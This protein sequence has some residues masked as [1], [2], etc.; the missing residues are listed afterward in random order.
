MEKVYV[1]LVKYLTKDENGNFILTDANTNEVF[2]K[3]I[4]ARQAINYKTATHLVIH[5]SEYVVFDTYENIL[6]EIKEAY[7]K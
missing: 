4:Q 5:K 2:T 1:L 3:L 7:F 6:Y